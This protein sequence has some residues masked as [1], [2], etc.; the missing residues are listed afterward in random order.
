M[1][2]RYPNGGIYRI[3]YI[4]L[5][6]YSSVILSELKQSWGDQ[7]IRF[8]TK[9]FIFMLMSMFIL[10]S[11]TFVLMNAVPGS[12]LQK[13]KATSAEVQKNLEAYYGLDKPL[14]KQYVIYMGNLVKFDLGISMKKK[15]Q[16]VDKMI[17]NSFSYSLKLGIVSIITS[18][19]CRHFTGNHCGALSSQISG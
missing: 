5:Y 11:A 14:Y 15:F 9:K 1:F 18:V 3:L 12:P 13:E 16:S 10:I 2:L 19:L 8:I 6:F 7:L 17:K 4:P